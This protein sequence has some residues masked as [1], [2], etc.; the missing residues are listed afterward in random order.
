MKTFWASEITPILFQN[1]EA[2]R[3]QGMVKG[4]DDR[5]S[6][7][8]VPR[9]HLLW[10][11]NDH[12]FALWN[13]SFFSHLST[14]DNEAGPFARLIAGFLQ[15]QFEVSLRQA[16]VAEIQKAILRSPF[17][18]LYDTLSPEFVAL[19]NNQAFSL[20]T[21]K[22]VFHSPETPI[23]RF[24]D[25]DQKH[26]RDP[27]PAFDKLLA[28][29]F[30]DDPAMRELIIE[31]LGYYMIPHDDEPACFFLYGAAASGKSTLLNLLK[32][33]IGGQEFISALSLQDLTTDKFMAANLSGKILNL[34]DEDESTH[35]DLGKLK[36]L[37]SHG[38]LEVQR[39]FENAF[40]LTPYAKF[41]FASNQLSQFSQVDQGMMRR[42]YLIEFKHSVP[43]HLRDKNLMTKLKAEFSGIVGKCLRAALAFVE[44]GQTFQVPASVEALKREFQ[45]DNNPV[46]A[47]IS[48]RYKASPITIANQDQHL[49]LKG[50]D[51]PYWIAN[52]VLYANYK[53]WCETNGRQAMSLVRFF[54]VLSLERQ[55]IPFLRYGASRTRYR[56]LVKIEDAERLIP[57]EQK[58]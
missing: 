47:F 28:D 34:Y 7:L 21:F 49:P 22:P 51:T 54:R 45:E 19:Q 11:E 8:V 43:Q 38:E 53:E 40:K 55:D 46:L 35:V 42:I 2:M 44:R 5:F 16:M 58:Y 30:P 6:L 10:L 41:I 33:L 36:L 18:T 32:L 27:T 20:R 39:K 13:G 3:N 56:G 12:T 26:F 15:Q 31:M 17:T 4:D 1:R 14:G 24:I 9:H 23:L 50:R 29:A 52:D 57:T 48:E 25:A 37:V